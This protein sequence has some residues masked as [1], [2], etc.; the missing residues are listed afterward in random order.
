MTEDDTFRVL[1]RT[2]AKELYGKLD[3]AYRALR[4]SINSTTSGSS[5]YAAA[6]IVIVENG[7]TEDEYIRWSISEPDATK[8]YYIS[9]KH[10]HAYSKR[11]II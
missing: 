5:W 4:R 8:I 11:K 7:W 2:S 9:S 6:M 3:D 10:M 1:S